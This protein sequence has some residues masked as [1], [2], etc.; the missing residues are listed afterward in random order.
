[1]KKADESS[2]HWSCRK[3][4]A[5][6]YWHLKFLLVL[7]KLLP[8]II[9]RILAF[10]VGFFYFIFS[11]R[12]RS[13]SR[14]FLKKAA[15]FVGD[16]RTAKKCRSPLGPLRHIVSFSLTLVEK[17]QSWAG[18]FS[19]KDIHFQND[20]IA[21]LIEGLENRKGAFLICSHL[22][23][24]ELL[25][26]LASFNKTGVSRSVP[27]TSIIDTEV[28]AHFNRML[29]ELNP[30]SALDIISA[31]A[32]SPDT[33]I[34]LEE[35]LAAGELVVIAGDRTSASSLT[36]GSEKSLMIPFLGEEAPFSHGAFYLAVLM[37]APIYFVFGLR[38]R[39]LSLKPE[40]DMYVH[41][42]SHSLECSRKER[43]AQSFELARSFA[44]L[45]ENYCKKQPFQWYNFYDFWAKE[46]KGV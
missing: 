9:L 13:E 35:K 39:A 17:I 16:P 14:R 11:K 12:S 29:K 36:S 40:Y 26:G 25:R 42:S 10:L 3:E 46:Y 32:I 6:G 38:R 33:A 27:V 34:I 15:L 24:A 45:L 8:L 41:K 37:K 44:A 28:T 5:A 4:Q 2:L 1:M 22:G 30:Q 19:F 21:E 23:N 7:F 18:K 31:K 43:L 20:D